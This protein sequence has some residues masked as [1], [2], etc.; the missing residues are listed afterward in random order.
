MSAT[1]IY[2]NTLTAAS[3]SSTNIETSNILALWETSLIL[4][5][6]EQGHPDYKIILQ[7]YDSTDFRDTFIIVNVAAGK[8][9]VKITPYGNFY[10]ENISGT[11][12]ERAYLYWASNTFKIG[13]ERAGSGTLRNIA[14]GAPN[15]IVAFPGT[16][17]SA[18]TFSGTNVYATTITGTTISGTTLSAT[19]CYVTTVTATNVNA[20]TLTGTTLSSTTLSATNCYVASVTATTIDINGDLTALVPVISVSADTVLSASQVKGQLVL[21]TATATI[22]LP[23]VVVGSVI[24]VY[25]TTAAAVMV[26]PNIND[27]IILNGV[28]GGNGKKITSTSV[29]GNFV[30]LIGDSADGWMLIGRSG[31]WTMES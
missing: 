1:D 28:A 6:H 31:T 5:S 22:S 3:F 11:D 30:T 7:G 15:T 20:T 17:L 25:S 9:P 18:G 16:S 26:D 2:A 27:R 29:A 10:I 14:I 21:V 24:T 23:A 19:N 4:Q 8:I 12:Y 13:T